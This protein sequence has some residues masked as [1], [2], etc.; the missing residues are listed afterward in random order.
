MLNKLMK[1]DGMA[2]FISVL[3]GLGLASFFRQ[4][5]KGDGCIVV[6]GPSIKEISNKVYK[7]DERCYKYT[8]HAS[9]C[10]FETSK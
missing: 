6:K 1:N 10:T 9:L 5:C 4:A 7:I 2:I 8:P 3:L